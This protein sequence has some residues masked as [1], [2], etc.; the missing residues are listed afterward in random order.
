TFALSRR[1]DSVSVLA[2]PTETIESFS[3]TGVRIG[4]V[5]AIAGRQDL[6]G[7]SNLQAATF[8]LSTPDGQAAYQH[9]MTTG[10][11]AHDTPGVSGV[12]RIGRV[13]MTSQ[14]RLKVDAGALGAIDLAGGM[15]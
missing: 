9:F 10:Q 5:T 2:G 3:G 12:A 4:D 15:A 8:D 7:A 11:V 13:D 14:P 1:G 6:L